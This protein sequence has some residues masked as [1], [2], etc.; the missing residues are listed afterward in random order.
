MKQTLYEPLKHTVYSAGVRFHINT[1]FRR[2]L[3][4]YAVLKDEVLDYP[5]KID[6]CLRLL[7]RGGR[8]LL[9]F[10]SRNRKAGLFEAVFREYVNT[11]DKEADA[12]KA[13][14]FDQDAPFIYA[15][16]WECYGI[17]LL[18]KDR[19][20]HWWKF[21]QL[22]KG[23]PENTRI[24]QIISIRT[25]PLPKATKYNAQERQNLMRLKMLYRVELTEEEQRK[26]RE[27]GFRK[28]AMAMEAMAQR[29][30]R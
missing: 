17:D 16:F 15:A 12:P 8:F 7:I 23:L 18:G 30:E 6:F 13:F 9:P 27:A 29:K 24:M 28:I 20:L 19:D 3:Q 10:L 25:R 11:G 22:F 21:I 2:V 14:D 26:Q 4:S 5:D 1:G